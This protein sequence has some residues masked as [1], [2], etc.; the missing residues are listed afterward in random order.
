MNEEVQISVNACSMLKFTIIQKMQMS[1]TNTALTDQVSKI[2][3]RYIHFWQD[4]WKEALSYFLSFNNNFFSSLGKQ[5]DST[6]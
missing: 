5:F 3:L 6:Y 2:I 1:I 4:G